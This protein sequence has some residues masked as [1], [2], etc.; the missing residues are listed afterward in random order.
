[1]T[2]NR[3]LG[4]SDL[5]AFLALSEQRD[6]ELRAV[7]VSDLTSTDDRMQALVDLAHLS[8]DLTALLLEVIEAEKSEAG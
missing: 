5:Q 1:M 2:R 8:S 4:L 6:Q 3:I 7:I